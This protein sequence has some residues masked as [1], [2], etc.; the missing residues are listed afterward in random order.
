MRTRLELPKQCPVKFIFDFIQ[1]PLAGQQFFIICELI[2][3]CSY[4]FL[5]FF[6]EFFFAY[7]V[8][9]SIFSELFIYAAIVFFFAGINSA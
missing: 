7:A 4:S 8:T 5:F 3:L 1:C 6:F 2:F 9:V